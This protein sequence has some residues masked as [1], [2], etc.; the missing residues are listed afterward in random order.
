MNIP[1]LGFLKGLRQIADQHDLL[2]LFDEIQVGL[3]RSGKLFCFQHENVIPDGLILGKALSGG[4]VPLSVFITAADVMDLVFSPGS[5]GST[6][7][8]Y[9]LACVAGIAALDVLQQEKLAERSARQ[10]AKLMKQLQQIA[11]RSIHVLQVRGRGLFI[12]IEM[13]NGNAMQFCRELLKLGVL[14][15]D[16]HGHTIR[17]SPPLIIDDVELDFMC[18]RLQQVL[19]Q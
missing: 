1:P 15:N 17:I 13:K 7:G 4:L 9:P 3:G 2:L 19:V 16:S 14:A 11:D 5:D 8:G 12:G 10:G 6:Y 18:E